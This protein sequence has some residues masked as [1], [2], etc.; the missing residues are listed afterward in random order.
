M[1]LGSVTC[2][3]GPESRNLSTA[4]IPSHVAHHHERAVNTLRLR[5]KTSAIST[6]LHPRTVIR[7]QDDHYLSQVMASHQPDP[8]PSSCRTSYKL[9]KQQMLVSAGILDSGCRMVMLRW[10]PVCRVGDPAAAAV[11]QSLSLPPT[12]VTSAQRRRHQAELVPYIR[13]SGPDM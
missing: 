13:H 10:V 9:V 8:R 7:H 1:G 11:L 6:S 12:A 2:H 5:D 3:P 4:S